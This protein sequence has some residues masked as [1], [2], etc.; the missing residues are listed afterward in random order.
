MP[1]NLSP[2]AARKTS[3]LRS[4]AAFAGL[5]CGAL[6][7]ACK[8]REPAPAAP[9][10]APVPAETSKAPVVEPKPLRLPPEPTFELPDDAPIDPAEELRAM[11]HNC[12]DEMSASEI[13]AASHA[14]EVKG[15][16]SPTPRRRKSPAD[17]SSRTAAAHP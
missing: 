9:S 1:R 10:H 7:G 11:G 3:L 15:A 6:L 13:E 8:L 14:G 17:R 12:C 2:F 5:L 16:A 4:H